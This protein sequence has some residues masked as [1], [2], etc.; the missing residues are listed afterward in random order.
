MLHRAAWI[1][2]NPHR[3]GKARLWNEIGA[4]VLD[5]ATGANRFITGDASRVT[6][7]PHEMVPASLAGFGAA[8]V[9]WRGSES[10]EFNGTPDPFLEMDW[11]YGDVESGR[12]LT[13]YD[14]FAV[15]VRL[16]G[17]GAGITEARVRGRLA[18]VPLR[19]GRLQF[20][21][22]Q[23]YEYQTNDAYQ[24][25][26]QSFDASISRT[27]GS[28]SGTRVMLLG[29]GG[30]TV[31]G[32]V[33]SLPVDLEAPPPE[34]EDSVQGV[35]E[36]PRYYDY[37]PGSLFGATAQITR[38]ARPLFTLFYEGRH[39]YSLDGVRAN[40]FLQRLRGDFVVPVRGPLGIGVT[41]EFFDRHTYFQDAN[42]TIK[43]YHYPQL[44]TYI[45]WGLS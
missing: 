34:Q 41:G 27:Y 38:N 7:K 12:S 13:P 36:G 21:V 8:G 5:P 11:L 25:G 44:S 31:L 37:G 17:G 4:M 35:S 39:L 2:R 45:A 18:G 32:A 43:S 22:I 9:M 3:T 26:S 19:S 42:H 20:S 14:A 23:D 28:G 24:T 1:V 30:L 6:D 29:W 40:H 10:G 33:D 16:G 15:R